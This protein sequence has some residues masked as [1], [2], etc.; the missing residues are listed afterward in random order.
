MSSLSEPLSMRSVNLFFYVLLAYDLF[1]LSLCDLQGKPLGSDSVSMLV[2]SEDD[3]LEEVPSLDNDV[4]VGS[5]A[6]SYSTSWSP[7]MSS[8]FKSPRVLLHRPIRP[9]HMEIQE[10]LPCLGH[11]PRSGVVQR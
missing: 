5:L 6:T 8:Y 7:H 3:S 1:Q 4:E 10:I 2:L 9:R 11:N